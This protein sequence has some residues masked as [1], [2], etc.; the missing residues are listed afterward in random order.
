[1][2]EVSGMSSLLHLYDAEKDAL[3]AFA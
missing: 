3:A 2:M 1:V